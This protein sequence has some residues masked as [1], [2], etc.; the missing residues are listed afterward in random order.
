MYKR[1]R[2][3]AQLAG[4]PRS[5]V[6][7]HLSAASVRVA[8]CINTPDAD[9]AQRAATRLEG[10]LP[11]RLAASGELGLQVETSPLVTLG[12]EPQM[13]SACAQCGAPRPPLDDHEVRVRVRV[14]RVR[15]RV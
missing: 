12:G 13:Q 4:T 3:L 15:V 14:V 1:Q 2:N 6:S 8:V 7:V 9:A 11:E 5:A 10:G